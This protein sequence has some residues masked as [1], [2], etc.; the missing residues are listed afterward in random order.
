MFVYPAN[1]EIRQTG[2]GRQLTGSFPYGSMATV[3]DRGRVRK[4][5]FSPRAFRFAV[6]D[7]NRDIDLL[8]GHRFDQP[9]ASK[10]AGTLVLEETDAGLSF[11]AELPIDDD[12]PSWMVDTVKAV[13]SRLARGISPGFR[14]PPASAVANAEEFLPE[15]GNPS[16]QIRQINQAVLVELSIVTRPSYVDSAVDIRHD[17]EGLSILDSPKEVY[18]RWL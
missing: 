6:E 5:R 3:R 17:V 9:L 1:L 15:P 11:R 8:A 4:E 18:Y 10:Q 12:Q 13:R 16:V 7:E 2:Q 14:V